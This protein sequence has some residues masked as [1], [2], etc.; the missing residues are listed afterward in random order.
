[1]SL[2]F[3]SKIFLTKWNQ[4]RPIIRKRIAEHFLSRRDL[5][6]TM[7]EMKPNEIQAFLEIQESLGP[8]KDWLEIEI[9]KT[10]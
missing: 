4:V 8:L 6:E 2:V 10:A 7:P 9:I 5:Y 3:Q 1:M